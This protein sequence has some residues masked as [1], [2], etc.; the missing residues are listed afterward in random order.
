MPIYLAPMILFCFVLFT[1]AVSTHCLFCVV[2]F[3]CLITVLPNMTS[4]SDCIYICRVPMLLMTLPV[5]PVQQ[6]ASMDFKRAYFSSLYFGWAVWY[7]SIC[8][9]VCLSECVCVCVDTHTH[10]LWMDC[11]LNCELVVCN[12]WMS[13]PG[14]VSNLRVLSG[15]RA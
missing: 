10:T 8:L 7:L 5:C 13:L 11:V 14:S 4:H 3:G 2:Q 1:L 12:E 6:V 9:S 15:E